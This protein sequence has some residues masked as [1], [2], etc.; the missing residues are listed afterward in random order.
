MHDMTKATSI[1]TKVKAAVAARDCVNGPA[2]C[3]ICGAPGGPWCH[4][5]RRS[6]GG[7]GIEKNI[8][9][10]CGQC[11]YS[12]DEGLFLAR[13]KPLGLNTQQ[14]VREYVID[15][16]KGFYPDWTEESVT[17]HKWEE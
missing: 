14:D 3:I 2:T 6:Q 13:L 7:R 9:T 12:L 11:H 10:L 15:Y 1:P 4:V 17:Y 8:V 5:V 16:L